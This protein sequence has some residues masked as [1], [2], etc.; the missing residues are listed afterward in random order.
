MWVRPYG[1]SGM[2]HND[3]V[4]TRRQ[5]QAAIFSIE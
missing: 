1:K 4:T 5:H 2:D 3:R